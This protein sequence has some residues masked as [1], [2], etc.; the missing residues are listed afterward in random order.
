MYQNNESSITWVILKG[1][2]SQRISLSLS[3]ISPLSWFYL[4]WDVQC[5]KCF[6]SF[7]NKKGKTFYQK[8]CGPLLE[9]L[10]LHLTE[11]VIMTARLGMFSS[12]WGYRC[13]FLVHYYPF[14][15]F[16]S[17]QILYYYYSSGNINLWQILTEISSPF[18]K[19]CFMVLNIKKKSCSFLCL[20]LINIC[21]YTPVMCQ[22]S[23]PL[24]CTLIQA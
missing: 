23:F 10:W 19:S 5:C 16:T 7:K 11:F 21:N 18:L 12:S 1:A 17:I 3:S 14:L 20:P 6:K 24:S 15:F 8:T 2:N 22:L 9:C 13:L 4:G